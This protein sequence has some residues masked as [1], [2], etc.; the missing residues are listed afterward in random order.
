MKKSNLFILILISL[1][2]SYSQSTVNTN[3]VEFDQYP[4]NLTKIFNTHGSYRKWKDMKQLSFTLDKNDGNKENHLID[5]KSR[6]LLISSS[7]YSIGFDGKDVWMNSTGKF[8]IDK[9][10]FY[11]SLF[12][13]FY[14]MPFVFGDSGIQYSKIDDLEFDNK[15]YS[16]IKITYEND[17][18]DSPD[19]SYF[20]YYDKKTY[21]MKWLGY[22]VTYG[23]GKTSSKV[24]FIKYS[25]WESI[26]GLLLP[27]KLEWYKTKNNLPCEF[28]NSV[29]F[30]NI[31]IL[32][33]K[34]PFS[35][36]IKPN[37]AIIGMK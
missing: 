5:L 20:I 30:E 35:M 18:G 34:L 13:Y 21:Q 11:H 1:Q 22:T 14:S 19:D 36:F 16:G 4:E 24:N 25:Q 8:P 15:S 17:I 28:S 29:S 7:K 12:F 37:D 3:K 2:I 10:R 32:E 33:T 26:N 27:Q 6:K 31:K 23:K 9:V